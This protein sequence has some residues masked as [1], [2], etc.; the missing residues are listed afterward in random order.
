MLG[1][2]LLITEKHL[3]A[4]HEIVKAVLKNKRKNIS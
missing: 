1:D 2:V 4:A 3:A